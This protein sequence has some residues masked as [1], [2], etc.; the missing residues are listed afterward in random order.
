MFGV[1]REE[2]AKWESGDRKPDTEKN[3]PVVAEVTGLSPVEL[4][5]DL[6]KLWRLV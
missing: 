1:C 3:L 5:P 2:V 6:K 4:R